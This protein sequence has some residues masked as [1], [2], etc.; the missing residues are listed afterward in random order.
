[1]PRPF[2][3]SEPDRRWAGQ[4]S[5]GYR[6]KGTYQLWHWFYVTVMG[7]LSRLLK[8]SGGGLLPDI[9]R[10]SLRPE[11]VAESP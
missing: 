9:G 7:A 10:H 5:R 1:M 2:G 3:V 6:S 4:D 11:N 8:M